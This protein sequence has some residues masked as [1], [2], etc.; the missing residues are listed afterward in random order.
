[1]AHTSH[2]SEIKVDKKI[3]EMWVKMKKKFYIFLMGPLS[4]I[5]IFCHLFRKYINSIMLYST[6]HKN[7]ILL[8]VLIVSEWA[9]FSSIT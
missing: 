9:F 6:D 3:N 8:F 4:M 1:M 5:Q 2:P 7:L